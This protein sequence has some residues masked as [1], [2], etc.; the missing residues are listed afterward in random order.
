MADS[1][2]PPFRNHDEIA[3]LHYGMNFQLRTQKK[4]AGTYYPSSKFHSHS[5]NTVRVMRYSRWLN[6]S[7][8]RQRHDISY[9]SF[10][11]RNHALWRWVTVWDHSEALPRPFNRQLT[12]AL[13]DHSTY[14]C[15]TVLTRAN[16]LETAVHRCILIPG[17]VSIMSLAC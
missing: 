4:N 8:S 13:V 17:L 6:K 10:I 9:S 14:C 12:F 16:Q 11:V 3:T 5:F 2:W 7:R 15:Y 1:G